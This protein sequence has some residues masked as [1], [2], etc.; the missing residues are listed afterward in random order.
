MDVTWYLGTAASTVH[1]IYIY[2]YTCRGT[3]YELLVAAFIY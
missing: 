1:N 3:Y 2:I